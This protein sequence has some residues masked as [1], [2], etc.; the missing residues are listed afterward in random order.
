MPK[1]RLCN[2]NN[3]EEN[4][5]I[6][7]HKSNN[8]SIWCSECIKNIIEKSENKENI[9]LKC[10]LCDSENLLNYEIESILEKSL[11]YI[12]VNGKLHGEN[13]RLYYTNEVGVNDYTKIKSIGNYNEGI[14]Y[15]KYIEYD[16]DGNIEVST[17]YENGEINGIYTTYKNGKILCEA[18]YEYGIKNGPQTYYYN[19]VNDELNGNICE[20]AIYKNNKLNGIRTIYDVKSKNKIAEINYVD[21][22]KDGLSIIYEYSTFLA[23]EE[24]KVAAPFLSNKKSS[25]EVGNNNLINKIENI[26][27]DDKLY[28]GIENTYYDNKQ[29][30]SNT[31]CING[32]KIVITYYENGKIKSEKAY[33]NEILHG[34]VKDYDINGNVVGEEFYNY[35]K[36]DG[37]VVKHIYKEHVKNINISGV[38]KVEKKVDNK[39]YSYSE[40]LKDDLFVNKEIKEEENQKRR[41]RDIQ[42]FRKNQ[43]ADFGS[44]ISEGEDKGELEEQFN[45]IH[46]EEHKNM[47]NDEDPFI[48]KIKEFSFM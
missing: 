40:L 14:L 4:L 1:C 7:C 30:K 19:N 29:I 20:I 15:G 32:Y 10:Q 16:K 45:N 2:Q 41:P 33:E 23:S 34:I 13:V 21:D 35:G 8:H 5:H 25:N 3:N 11:N 22:K 24:Q 18:T 36:L 38:K 31:T 46:F 43:F 44:V 37:A 47:M 28:N 17:V 39:S 26:Y 27:K 42:I 48:R 9:I 6:I 12:Y